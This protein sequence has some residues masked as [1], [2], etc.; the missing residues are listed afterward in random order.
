[1]ARSVVKVSREHHPQGKTF[2]VRDYT[3]NGQTRRLKLDGAVVELVR[4]YVAEHGI[5]EAEVMF[6]AELVVP[7]RRTKAG[8]TEE[9]LQAL[10]DCEPV[11]GRV[12]AHGTLGGY[13]QAKCRCAGCRQWARTALNNS[14][15][16]WPAFLPAMS[17][18][19]WDDLVMQGQSR[20]D[21]ELLDAGEMAGHLIPPGSV[22]AFLAGHRQELFPDSFTA[23]LFPSRTGRPSL[24]ADLVGAVLVL[25]ELHDLSDTQTAEALAFDIRWKVACGRSLDQMSFDPSTLVYWRKRIAASDRPDR[26]FDAVAEVIVQTGILRGR[27]KRCVDSTVFDDAVATQDTVTQLMAAMRKVTRVVP[28]A[29]AVISRV[30]TLDYSKP[31][32]P[33]IDWDDR[34][35]KDALV[36]DLVNDA[37]AVLAELAGPDAPQRDAAAADAL[38]LLA[39]AAGQDVEPAEDSDG[40]DGRWRIARKVAPDRVISTVDRQARHTRKSKS[41]R[42]DG[43]RGHV[44]AEPQTGLVTDCEMTMAAGEGSTD[45]ENGVKMAARD[46][47]SGTADGAEPGG[48]PQAGPDGQTG[49]GQDAGS[50]GAPQAARLEVYG[51]SAYGSG[52]ARAV[53]RDAGHDTVIK[54]GPLRPAVPGGFTIDDFTIDEQ[55]GTVT[56]PAGLTRPMTK[57]RTVTFGAACAACP[58]RERCTTA[59]DGRSMTIHPHEDLLRAARAQARTPEF[60]RAYPTRSAIERIIAWTATQNGRRIR[61]R[62]IGTAKNNAWLHGRCAAI[63]LRTLLRHGL[64][65]RDGAWVLA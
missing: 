16:P 20:I 37:L 63:N 31:G 52:E 14:G 21:R 39:L 58:L 2:L 17:S 27:R 35:A 28:G 8:L 26:V 29:G 46:R 60:R 4:G 9:Q 5:G 54:P 51:D 7:P 55:A 1:V 18:I 12:Y 24:P 36:S 50:A 47:F 44:A 32:K 10:G 57:T 25:K 15:E 62:Y 41:K 33:A 6:P 13:V 42:R 49:T 19:I 53:Y 45:A 38:G 30:C 11:D 64:T 40:T 3:K 22:F 34:A 23:D 59:K 48:E 65:R 61:L 43:F 56:C